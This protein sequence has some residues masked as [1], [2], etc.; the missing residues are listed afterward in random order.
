[1]SDSIGGKKINAELS[2][3]LSTLAQIEVKSKS[4]FKSGGDFTG[5]DKSISKVELGL[6]HIQSIIGSLTF[7]DLKIPDSTA[8]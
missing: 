3:V 2:K 8:T 6:D 5:L 7:K 1:L 4:A